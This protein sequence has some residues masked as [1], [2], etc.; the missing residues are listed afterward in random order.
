[1]GEVWRAR[2]SRLG[3]DVAIKALPLEFADDPDR[4]A[5]FDREARVLASLNHAHI[6][7][8]YGLEK[9]DAQ[10][11]LVL[12]L[13]EG[14]TI[15][16][17]IARG[18]LPLDEALRLAIQIA[19]AIEAAHE[20][21]IIHRDLKPANIKLTPDGSIKV[22]DFG[23]A[24]V[25]A[26]TSSESS[27]FDS[28][29]VS[30]AAT[31]QGVI[32]G[33]AAY[34]SPEQAR[35]QV[36]DRRTD[37]WAFGCVLYEMLTGRH[38]FRG[39]HVSDIL[40]AVLAREPDY[41]E[42]P[43]TLPPRLNEA[44]RRCF[45]KNP[46]RRW[47]AIG[48][49]RVGLEQI[50][51]DP[52]T[53]AAP[54]RASRRLIALAAAAA[55]LVAAPAGW[56]LRPQPA[57]APRPIV[58]FEY[59]V[60]VTETPFLTA[61]RDVLAVSPEGRHFAYSSAAGLALR[62]FDAPQAAVIPGT[63]TLGSDPA[64]SPDGQWIADWSHLVYANGNVLYAVPFDLDTLTTTGGAVPVVPGVQRS[65]GGATPAANYGI[66]TQGTLIYLAQ[67]SS[68]AP[69]K[70]RSGSRTAAASF[71]HSTCRQLR[72]ATR[73]SRLTAGRSRSKPLAR[74]ARARSG[75]M[76]RRAAPRCGA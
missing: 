76:T 68:L 21:D 11:F 44:L 69:R 66:T 41:G 18:A 15:A 60:P 30:L 24:K 28:P 22:L 42:L 61:D 71:A 4:L 65:V 5:R 39:E 26:A 64:F 36:V 54:A 57:P 53:A 75:S 17:R 2:D 50:L 63:E 73:A 31:A 8:I 29:T 52:S 43:P 1:M 59:N 74:T 12:E 46:K 13:V 56:F 35:G 7:A 48:D 33:T 47:Q 25:F 16:A 67:F 37:I 38:A 34:M 20:K 40:A 62:S 9:A 3:R 55:A 72:T 10:S 6:A 32:L 51:A 58:R 49:L 27:V 23:L 70:P 14:E 45:E 19:D